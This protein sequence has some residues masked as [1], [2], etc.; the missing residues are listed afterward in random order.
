M[1]IKLEKDGKFSWTELSTIYFVYSDGAWQVT[2]A[3]SYSRITQTA[4]AIV[5]EVQRKA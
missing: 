1:P 3:G 2:D 5:S 4:N